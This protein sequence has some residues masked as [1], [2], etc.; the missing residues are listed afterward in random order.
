MGLLGCKVPLLPDSDLV[1][2]GHIWLVRNCVMHKG[3]ILPLMHDI[4]LR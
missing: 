3:S 2:I 1:E 4:V